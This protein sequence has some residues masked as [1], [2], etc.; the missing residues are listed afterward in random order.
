[1]NSDSETIMSFVVLCRAKPCG[2]SRSDTLCAITMDSLL[3]KNK[4]WIKITGW[5]AVLQTLGGWGVLTLTAIDSGAIPIPVDALVAGYVLANPHR[6]WLYVIA[7][8]TGSA[9]G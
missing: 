5:L 9:I 2:F 8:A 4:L 1:M 7:G 3:A 6:A